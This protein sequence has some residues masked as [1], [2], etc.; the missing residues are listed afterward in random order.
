MLVY[1]SPSGAELDSPDNLTATP[2][3]GLVA[4]EDDASRSRG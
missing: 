4:C 3:G 1:E 2:R